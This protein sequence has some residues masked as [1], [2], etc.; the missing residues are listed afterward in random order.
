VAGRLTR[1]G[2]DGKAHELALHC[3]GTAN[4][5][6]FGNAGRLYYGYVGPRAR[7]VLISQGATRRTLPVRDGAYLAVLRGAGRERPRITVVLDDGTHVRQSPSAPPI[8]G[9][10][11][12][13]PAPPGPVKPT[14]IVT[15]ARVIAPH[16]ELLVTF[17]APV[18][19]GDARTFYRVEAN[20]PHGRDCAG[21]V[22]AATDRDYTR[23]DRVRLRL[24][25][26][27]R[28][29]ARLIGGALMPWCRGS[30]RGRVSISGRN[31]VGS[32]SLTVR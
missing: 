24:R 9:T 11:L 2:H 8:P 21:R 25:R 14:P 23:G 1:I 10:L 13:R 32:F 5:G 16:G 20:G 17:R 6:S 3:R 7:S 30:F 29:G 12:A 19:I 18:T 15:S 26:P 31:T 4:P 27:N 28:P 22:L